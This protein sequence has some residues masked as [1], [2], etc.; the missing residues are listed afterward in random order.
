MREL[1]H[2]HFHTR[3]SHMK[4]LRIVV[5]IAFLAM[6]CVGGLFAQ[7]LEPVGGPYTPDSNTVVLLHFD[8]NLRNAAA[9]TG[10]T[11]TALVIHSSNPGTKVYFIANSLAGMGQCVRLDNSAV[12]DS[13]YLTLADT[14]ALDLTGDWTMEAWVNIFTFGISSTDWRWVPRFIMKPGED[15]FWHPN[16]W[17]E[18]WGDSRSYQTGFWTPQ[19]QFISNTSENNMFTPGAWVHM[20][21]VRDTQRGF[22]A[23]LV[24]DQDRNLVSFTTRGFNPATQ[25][26]NT[27]R[28]PLHIGWAGAVGIA[29]PSV[30]SWLDGFV[31]EIRISKVVRKFAGPAVI[32]DVTVLANQPTTL[33][34]Y[35]IDAKIQPF[36]PGSSISKAMLYYSTSAYLDTVWSAWDSVAMSGVGINYS[37]SI[38]GQSTLGTRVRYYVVAAD[39]NGFRTYDPRDAKLLISPVYYS[40]MTFEQNVQTM[41]MTFDEGPG[42]LPVDH[43]PHPK[44]VLVKEIPTYSSTEVKQGT[45]A[46]VLRYPTEPPDTLQG[47]WVRSPFLSA[48]EF[49]LDF[50]MK[51]DTARPYARVI[52]YPVNYTNWNDANFEI[53]LRPNGK[54]LLAVTGRYWKSDLSGAVVLQD[55]NGLVFHKWQRVILERSKANSVFSLMIK[56]EN[57]AQV[58]Y[59]ESKVEPLAPRMGASVDD[60]AGVNIGR[61][62]YTPGDFWGIPPFEGVFDDVQLYNYPKVGITDVKFQ[63]EEGLPWTFELSQNYPNPFNPSTRIAFTIPKAGGVELA[64]FDILGRKVKTLVNEERHA[65]QHF[66]TWNGTD[67][68]GVGVA[69]GVYFCKLNSAGMEKVQKMM[70]MK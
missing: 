35:V 56:D 40:F 53:G 3:R 10:K 43:S 9:D 8:G 59:H 47:V 2:T 44:T 4:L 38:P 22:I 25:I 52:N 57:D 15:V 24:H 16:Y 12:T 69:S 48:E 66:V 65:G 62:W 17:N 34:A 18:M 7:G 58:I 31:D 61:S 39:E 45:H 60:T 13:T 42:N 55:T 32:T 50:W 67:D 23:Q 49:C 70:L 26:P 63:Y 46:L 21:F 19:D 33:P 41:W 20:T 36:S 6:V 51:P 11:D 29:E 54:G 14:A 37:G 30:D 68:R 5:P 28:N 1:L 64:V 27:N